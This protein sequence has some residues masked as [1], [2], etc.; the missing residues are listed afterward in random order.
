MALLFNQRTSSKP[1]Y[2]GGD[3]TSDMINTSTY[4]MHCVHLV[5]LGWI[6]PRRALK[7]FVMRAHGASELFFGIGATRPRVL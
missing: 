7:Q 6:A 4:R 1:P 3:A 2:H 5:C